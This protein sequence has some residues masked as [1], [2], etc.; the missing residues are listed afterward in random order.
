M[1]LDQ[2]NKQAWRNPADP[3][4]IEA[5]FSFDVLIGANA[6]G[7]ADRY[8]DSDRGEILQ[9]RIADHPDAVLSRTRNSSD[10][11]AQFVRRTDT[12]QRKR[13]GS[14]TSTNR[15]A[16]LSAPRPYAR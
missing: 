1:N 2:L 9:D 5:E 3:E 11:I 16:N 13:D 6:V 10:A 15:A 12:R 14:S 7:I 4:R 8:S